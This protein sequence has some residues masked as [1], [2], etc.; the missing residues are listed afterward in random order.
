MMNDNN[1]NHRFIGH[2]QGKGENIYNIGYM[3]ALDE[4]SKGTHNSHRVRVHSIKLIYTILAHAHTNKHIYHKS[5]RLVENFS[6]RPFD[7]LENYR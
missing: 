7:S 6:F 3:H 4:S 1:N 5:A 2:F